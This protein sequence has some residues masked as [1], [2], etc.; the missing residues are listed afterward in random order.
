M[1]NLSFGNVVKGILGICRE[2]II[3]DIREI[4]GKEIR[5]DHSDIRGKQFLLFRTEYPADLLDFY[6]LSFKVYLV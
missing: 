6:I 1:F 2:I 5:H 4:I 3:H